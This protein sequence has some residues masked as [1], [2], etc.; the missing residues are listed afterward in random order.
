MILQ[1]SKDVVLF[2]HEVSHSNWKNQCVL[3]TVRWFQHVSTYP[4]IWSQLDHHPISN[5]SES[6]RSH[7]NFGRASTGS[8]V[9]MGSKGWQYLFHFVSPGLH[10]FGKSL[11][12]SQVC[13]ALPVRMWIPRSKTKN[14][15]SRE[16]GWNDTT[17]SNSLW[18][19]TLY[20][21]LFENIV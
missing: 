2:L 14:D 20:N 21:Q 5:Q 1:F 16:V 4:K 17:K 8:A 15:S 6:E 9:G 18:S 7:H 12:R 3:K 10:M 11:L 13:E 19:F